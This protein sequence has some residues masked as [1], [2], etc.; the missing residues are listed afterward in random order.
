MVRL[1]LNKLALISLS[2][3]MTV[4][5]CKKENKIDPNTSSTS[6]P[7]QFA[8][9]AEVGEDQESYLT[10]TGDLSNGKIS[11]VGKGIEGVSAAQ[12][13]SRDGYLYIIN[14]D[15]KTIDKNK[16]L[17]DGTLSKEGTSLSLNALVPGGFFRYTVPTAD[18]DIF[19]S[20]KPDKDGNAP[21]AIVNMESFSVRNSGNFNIPDVNGYDPLWINTLV[22]GDKAYI[23]GAFGDFA[24][25]SNIPDSLIT[26]VYDYPSMTNPKPIV[27][28]AS[29]GMA[30]GYRSNSMMLTETGDIYHHNIQSPNWFEH[31]EVADKPSVFVKITNEDYDDSYK[32]DVTA[33]FGEPICIWNA[34]YAG[35]GIAYANVVKESDISAWGDLKANTG[36][37]T[38]IDLINKTVTPLNIPKAPYVNI[39]Q[40]NCIKDGKFYAP[41]SLSGGAANIYEINIGGGA[42]G[43]TKGAELDGSNVFIHSL[44]NNF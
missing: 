23:S 35:N 39:F 37:L 10:M 30:C 40:L 43:F 19:F 21:F 8:V 31:D 26:V 42:S 3:L 33:A 29:G 4:S 6:S 38:E 11:I 24:T 36:T 18:G 25:W 28:P 7:V 16:I 41:V 12:S 14:F 27:S 20:N 44:Q 34:W 22:K 2:I 17:D 9:G 5:S 1:S 32:L 15:A 13:V